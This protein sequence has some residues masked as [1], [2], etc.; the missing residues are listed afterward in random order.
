M[1]ND[2]STPG[3]SKVNNSKASDSKTTDSKVA[4]SKVADSKTADSKTA[5]SKTDN[6]EL[7]HP[8]LSDQEL[9]AKILGE[10]SRI[11]WRDLEIFYAK[12]Q[13]V[14]V[15]S[16]LD[17]IEACLALTRDDKAAV[18]KW[19]DQQLLGALPPEKAQ[20]WHDSEQVVWAAVVAPW[21]LVQES[22]AQP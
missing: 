20:R 14:E 21:V 19:M 13:V 12:G 18:E 1:T 17:L 5:D 3:A 6:P 11:S 10:T 2:F 7:N 4:D 9:Q 8:K 22:E 15:S 16:N